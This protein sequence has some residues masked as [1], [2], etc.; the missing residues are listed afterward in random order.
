MATGINK[1]E[2][3]GKDANLAIRSEL[4]DIP[5]PASDSEV[6]LSYNGKASLESILQPVNLNFLKCNKN[7]FISISN[8]KPNSFV[9]ADNFYALHDLIKN[10][11]KATLIYIDPPYCTGLEFHSRSLEHAY[12][13]NL[14]TA[15][16]IEYMRRRLILMS[17]ILSDDGS[18]YVHIGHQ[19]LA[20]MK[21]LMDEIFGDKNFRNIIT[22]RKCSSKNYTQKQYTNL[23]DYILFYSK[24]SNYKWN[25]P[26]TS[27]DEEWI[28][29]E[30]PKE[31]S[32]GRYKLVPIHAPGIRNG[33]TG[34]EWKGM[35]PPPG[36][37]WQ[38]VPEKL[39]EFDKKGEIHWSKNGNPRRKVYFKDDKKLALSDYWTD[40]RDAHHQSI[41]ITGY[42]T[43]KNL[44]MLKMII[45]ASSNPGDIVV[46]P[47]CGSG[48]TLHA[49]KALNRKWIGID[50]SFTAAKTVVTRL[51]K[52]LS[53]MGDYVNVESNGATYKQT[54]L[55]FKS[56]LN[57][58]FI[59]DNHLLEDYKEDICKI[60][61][62]I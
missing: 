50:Q 23:N 47:F 34:K 60:V 32:K 25:Q 40:F 30:Y 39:D 28:K 43:E 54:V 10:N 8:I 18:I 52:G 14:G 9:L 24:S 26:G 51:V 2:K 4:L 17:E 11:T 48:T 22:R 62:E 20:Y 21:V 29:K 15:T 41:K 42:P 44:E 59:V 38:Y 46:D 37:H 6:K 45:N 33:E 7:E 12:K 35:L 58:D 5:L 53:P 61:N 31:D 3:R 13:D 27:P 16:Y 36:K 55:Q 49:A 19:M 1:N 57:F 56:E